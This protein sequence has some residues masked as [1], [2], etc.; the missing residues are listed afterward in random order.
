[1]LSFRT[2]EVYT[3]NVFSSSVFEKPS[4]FMYAEYIRVLA[5]FIPAV[6]Y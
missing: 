5:A 1:M 6:F 4:C 2:K 3:K